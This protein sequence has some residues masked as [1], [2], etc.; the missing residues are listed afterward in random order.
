MVILEEPEILTSN[1][2]K[3]RQLKSSLLTNLKLIENHQHTFTL[4]MTICVHP[5]RDLR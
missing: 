1:V 4:S 5:N 2:D 3:V